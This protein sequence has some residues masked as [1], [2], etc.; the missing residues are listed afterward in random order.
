MAGESVGRDP[1]K[2]FLG[3]VQRG[4]NLKGEKEES[5]NEPFYLGCRDVSLGPGGDGIML[6]VPKRLRENLKP[7][8]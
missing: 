8:R 1:R 2:S 3:A 5:L 4:K 6:P 7:K